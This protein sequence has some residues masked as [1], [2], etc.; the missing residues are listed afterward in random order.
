MAKIRLTDRAV[1]GATSEGKIQN[2][3]FDT[4][5]TGLCLRVSKTGRKTWMV[6]YTSPITRKRAR[7]KI[8]TYPELSLANARNK[9]IATKSKVADNTDPQAEKRL[10]TQQ[11]KAQA[12][13]RSQV[14]Q[15]FKKH[16]DEQRLRSASELRR[17]F[18]H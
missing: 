12:T 4:Q 15:Y 17:R 1:V 7:I 3:Y 14:E 13:V 6:V 16:V 10:A 8:G 18:D 5:V 11:M 9:A 2:D